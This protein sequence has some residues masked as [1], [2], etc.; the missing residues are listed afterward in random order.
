MA[1]ALARWLH[2]VALSKAPDVTHQA[3]RPES[4]R[5]TRIA[6]KIA[7]NS[8]AFFVVIDSFFAHNLSERSCYGQHK[9]KSS[10]LLFI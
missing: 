6:I 3:M 4:Y 8:P 10:Y 7:S 9:F 5:L 2:L 1:Q